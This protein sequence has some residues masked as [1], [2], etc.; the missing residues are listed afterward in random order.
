MLNDSLEELNHLLFEEMRRLSEKDLTANRAALEDEGFRAEQLCKTAI[1]IVAVGKLAAVGYELADGSFGKKRL[2]S[3]FLEE[4]KGEEG[5]ENPGK[6]GPD[7]PALIQFSGGA[8]SEGKHQ[9]P[10]LLRSPKVI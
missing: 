2:P 1:A 10:K 3:L 8:V 9:R 7:A 5:K 6:G 4:G